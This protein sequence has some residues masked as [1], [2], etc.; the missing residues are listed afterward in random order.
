MSK[1]LWQTLAFQ[2][3]RD[4]LNSE[5]TSALVHGICQELDIPELDELN[6]EMIGISLFWTSQAKFLHSGRYISSWFVSSKI[7]QLHFANTMEFL[8]WLVLDIG[9]L[10]KSTLLSN[11]TLEENHYLGPALKIDSIS[12]SDPKRSIWHGLMNENWFNDH[13]YTVTMN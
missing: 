4:Q 6:Q 11:E 2:A 8:E 12:A 13:S 5:E 7:K 9:G 3:T 10:E 1:P